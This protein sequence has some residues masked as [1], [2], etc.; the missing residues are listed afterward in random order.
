MKVSRTDELMKF[1][2]K[3]LVDYIDVASKNFWT[4]QNNYMVN[5][6]S[7]YGKDVAV[8]FD[9]LCYGRF[10]EVEVYRLKKLF[11][12]GNDI[13]ALVNILKL[14]FAMEE[15]IEWEFAEVTDRKVHW[16][17]T[18][19]P[20]QLARI[21]RGAPELTCKEALSRNYRRLGAAVSP[22]IKMIN[23]YAPPDPHPEDLWCGVVWELEQ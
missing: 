1:T 16:R 7:R 2:K 14:D 17:V 5:L 20:M 22:R 10:V 15:G 4:L 18:R 23:V 11:D 21:A 9:A 13:P 6:E 8:E 12:L 19:C 3:Q